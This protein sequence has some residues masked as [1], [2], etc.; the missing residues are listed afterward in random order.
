MKIDCDNLKLDRTYTVVFDM[1]YLNSARHHILSGYRLH[2]D[3]PANKKNGFLW[4]SLK[5]CP[6]F[7]LDGRVTNVMPSQSQC[8]VSLINVLDDEEAMQRLST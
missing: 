7:H 4:N 1:L 2:Y 8:S 5:D 3:S 6:M